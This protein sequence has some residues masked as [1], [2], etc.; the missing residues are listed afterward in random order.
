[1]SDLWITALTSAGTVGLL[2][3]VFQAIVGRRKLSADA[4]RVIEESATSAVKRV[5]DDNARLR[6]R[7]EKVEKLLDDLRRELR[8]RDG[9]IDD[10]SDDLDDA[11]EH[12]R[13]LREE[14]LRQD[15]TLTLPEPPPRIARHFP[16]P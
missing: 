11:L 14:L 15:P 5:E 7:V 6:D 2:T 9:R 10:L 1:M 3:A 13:E 4:A 16:P 8:S 12:I